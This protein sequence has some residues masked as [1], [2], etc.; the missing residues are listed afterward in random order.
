MLC[1]LELYTFVHSSWVL[2]WLWGWPVD[3]PQGVAV[4]YMGSTQKKIKK[5]EKHWSVQ[6]TGRRSINSNSYTGTLTLLR[7]FYGGVAS[8]H[9]TFLKHVLF[10]K[11]ISTLTFLCIVLIWWEICC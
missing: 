11:D 6:Y 1:I 8:I 3:I 4:Y 5:V 9:L 7:S 10:F 2:W